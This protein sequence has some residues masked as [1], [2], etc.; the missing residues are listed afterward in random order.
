MDQAFI[1]SRL[2]ENFPTSIKGNHKTYGCE[3]IVVKKDSM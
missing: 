3:T 1:L 2:T